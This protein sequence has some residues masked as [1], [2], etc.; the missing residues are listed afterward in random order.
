MAFL[1]RVS[2]RAHSH[3]LDDL[4]LQPVREVRERILND[5]PH[6][7]VVPSPRVK[8]NFVDVSFPKP[9]E[10]LSR[11]GVI[12]ANVEK[13]AGNPRR[14]NYDKEKKEN[15]DL[16]KDKERSDK[17]N[18]FSNVN[19][20]SE[21][22]RREFLSQLLKKGIPVWEEVPEDERRMKFIDGTNTLSRRPYLINP[23]TSNI[24]LRSSNMNQKPCKVPT[25]VWEDVPQESIN[26]YPLRPDEDLLDSPLHSGRSMEERC[27][28]DIYSEVPKSFKQSTKKAQSSHS[29]TH[30]QNQHSDYSNQP[31]MQQTII[32]SQ[33]LVQNPILHTHTGESQSRQPSTSPVQCLS[34]NNYSP[35]HTSSSDHSPEHCSSQKSDTPIQ[36]STQSHTEVSC[37]AQHY[38][39]LP[40]ESTALN[41]SEEP[42]KSESRLVS[43]ERH[44]RP[45][46]KR[47]YGG[48]IEDDAAMEFIS[49]WPGDKPKREK[50]KDGE[51]EK[52]EKESTK[53][54]RGKRDLSAPS[55]SSTEPPLRRHKLLSNEDVESENLAKT[56]PRVR[57]Y[58]QAEVRKY[59]EAKRSE[60]FKNR[61][62]QKL[63]LEQ[64]K[65]KKE[66]RLKELAVK[67]KQL[68]PCNKT[69]GLSTTAA[70][71]NSDQGHSN[72]KN[73]PNWGCSEDCEHEVYPE[74]Q[75]TQKCAQPVYQAA[76][77]PS[78]KTENACQTNKTSLELSKEE[79]KRKSTDKS[80]KQISAVGKDSQRKKKGKDIK[81]K[82]KRKP[83]SDSDNISD[84]VS[85]TVEE[86]ER[87]VKSSNVSLD[88]LSSLS[89]VSVSSSDSESKGSE[90]SVI[91][92]LDLTP[93][94]RVISLAQMAQKLTDRI[95][96]EEENLK[97]HF[98][99]ERGRLDINMESTAMSNITERSREPLKSAVGLSSVKDQTIGASASKA[100]MLYSEI[101]KLSIEDLIAKM[102]AMLPNVSQTQ[103]GSHATNGTYQVDSQSQKKTSGIKK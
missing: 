59:M 10:S 80:P 89:S 71:K 74:I 1:G 20:R 3:L 21:S 93:K 42:N 13:M 37:S 15:R 75:S 95:T 64:E 18:K 76:S 52:H 30:V 48:C 12:P 67:T 65:I 22:D 103:G 44:S 87:Q 56:P 27:C 43:Q 90:S 72:I 73:P 91:S 41:H 7:P 24:T 14:R 36:D 70:A 81:A 29:K 54:S 38:S 61:R 92:G 33:V 40:M 78:H 60:R 5:V 23:N 45:A 6:D 25:A 85:R 9:Q 17:E 28:G 94:Q 49:W 83:I 50:S 16:T 62:E 31:Q 84:I 66:E 96:Q 53:E 55:R 58:E 98:I 47:I 100:P 19:Q 86:C 99:N 101:E 69:E 63:Q 46:L 79:T 8:F 39:Q 82:H 11:P 68:A 32:Q 4:D 34:R 51:E 35:G 57:K 102:T 88:S 26:S 2:S 77:F 97:H